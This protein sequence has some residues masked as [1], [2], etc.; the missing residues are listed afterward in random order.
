[1]FVYLYPCMCKDY[2]CMLYRNKN[3]IQL[4]TDIRIRS[5]KWRRGKKDFYTLVNCWD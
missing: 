1:M 4:T 5:W 3:K 2:F